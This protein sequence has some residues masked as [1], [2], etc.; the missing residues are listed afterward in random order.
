LIFYVCGP[1]YFRCHTL[2]LAKSADADSS[3]TKRNKEHADGLAAGNSRLPLR[4]S[5]CALAASQ[6]DGQASVVKNALLKESGANVA[7][8]IP[9]TA[10]E[11]S[12]PAKS[13]IQKIVR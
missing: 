9:A 8:S 11:F 1:T 5:G 7:T 6:Q 10:N 12:T 2:T 3:H 4:T 13:N